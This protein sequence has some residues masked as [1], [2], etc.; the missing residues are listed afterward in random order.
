MQTDA[1]SH[2][3][4]DWGSDA[5]APL[6]VQGATIDAAIAGTLET[7]LDVASGREP[8][9]TA[10]ADAASISA[11]I[12]G[13]GPSY[14]EALFELANDLLAQLDANGTGLTAV[15]LDGVLATDD[16]GFTAWGNAIGEAGGGRPPLNL[17]LAGTP[18]VTQDDSGQ[19]T[20]TVTLS[21]A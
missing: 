14:G 8:S 11:P 1:F 16:G 10:G 20:I 18:E 17:S 19:T 7:I 4:G 21:R 15:R 9:T 12:R 5:S 6:T 3:L 13:Q 2:T